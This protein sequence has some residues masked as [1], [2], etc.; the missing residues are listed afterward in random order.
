MKE[1][2]IMPV[3]LVIAPTLFLL[4]MIVLA[5][6]HKEYEEILEE[7]DRKHEEDEWDRIVPFKEAIDSD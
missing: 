2:L 1:I 5:I 6:F 7:H 4:T 3:L